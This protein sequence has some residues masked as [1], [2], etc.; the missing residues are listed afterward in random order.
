MESRPL[1]PSSG[2]SLS[3]LSG[4]AWLRLEGTGPQPPMMYNCICDCAIGTAGALPS[5]GTRVKWQA[6]E[7]GGRKGGTLAGPDTGAFSRWGGQT[8]SEK[9]DSSEVWD[10]RQ[11]S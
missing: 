3:R 2:R 7:L 4:P 5:S 9:D 6:R 1:M 8:P 11:G 10:K